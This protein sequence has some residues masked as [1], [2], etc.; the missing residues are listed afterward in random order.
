MNKRITV[1]V[2]H[3][4]DQAW[5]NVRA[6][7]EQFLLEGLIRPFVVV[8]ISSDDDLGIDPV[9]DVVELG[10]DAEVKTYTSTFFGFLASLG[11]ISEVSVVGLRCDSSGVEDNIS[12]STQLDK[13][14]QSI[15]RLLIQFAGDLRQRQVRCAIIGEGEKAPGKPFFSPLADV[16]VVAMPRDISMTRA[17][18]RPILRDN[19]ESFI[20]HAALE[21]SSIVGL[22][23]SMDSSPLDDIQAS[24]MGVPG[25]RV[26][27]VTSRVKGLLTPPLPIADLVDDSS[28]LPLPN[29]FS[30]VENLSSVVDRYADVV[31]PANMLFEPLGQ[32][33]PHVRKGWRKIAGAYVSEFWRTVI[34]IPSMIKQGFEGEI[35]A[36]GANALDRL[37]G[38]AD[39]RIRPIIPTEVTNAS[40][41]ITSEVVEEIIRDIELRE[42]RPVVGALTSEQWD[43]M[44]T[45]IL[46]IADAHPHSEAIRQS[47]MPSGI[48]VREKVRLAPKSETVGEL[49]RAIMP[50]APRI[51]EREETT[52]FESDEL[53]EP[54]AN[55]EVEGD[56]SQAHAPIAVNYVTGGEVD[57]DAL[58]DAVRRSG[59]TRPEQPEQEEQSTDADF[60]TAGVA[61]ESEN[62][63]ANLIG[64]IT[65]RFD[66]E[67]N[68]AEDSVVE[69]LATLRD[70]P[71]K[72]GSSEFGGVSRAVI[73]TVAISMGAI[74]VSLATHGV[75]RDLFSLDWTS[76]RNRDF[77]WVALSSVMTVIALAAMPSNSRR[78]WQSKTMSTVAICAGILAVE[79]VAFDAV[80]DRIIQSRWAS[81]TAVVAFI[82]LAVTSIITVLSV[83]RNFRSED[84]I[85]NRISR[86]LLAFFWLYLV[87]GASS[88]IAGPESFIINW[89]D[90]TRHKFLIAVQFVGWLCLIM[91]TLVIVTVR[92]QQRNA[93]GLYQET[94]SW[95]QDNLTHSI[96]ARRHLR[97]AYTQWLTVAAMLS[98]TIWYPLGREASDSAPF[99]G[100]LAGDESI[101]KFDLAKVELSEQGRSALLAQLKQMFVRKGWLRV[102][103]DYAING[104]QS[105]IA[106]VTQDPFGAHDP[107]SCAGVPE[108]EDLL[109]GTARGDRYLFAQQ[110]LEGKFDTRLLAQATNDNLDAVYANILGHQ[111][112]HNIVE[113]Q[114]DFATGI[115]FL[116]DIVPTEA[117]QLPPRILNALLVPSDEA[118]VLSSHRWWPETSLLG[119]PNSDNAEVH[120]AQ[121][122]SGAHLNESVVMMA[123][124]VGVSSGF[125]NSQV[126][127]VDDADS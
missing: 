106:F 115:E 17:V 16:N 15:R 58:R 63:E 123:V 75:L 70:L 2:A 52:E 11:E 72:F 57:L 43:R 36:V 101:L 4:K 8:S 45:E 39:A 42:G 121:V 83:K 61:V 5:G 21:I 50:P 99:E 48:L 56:E 107:L 120:T 85:R 108:V 127:C 59:L 13:A 71:S 27:L 32:P 109:A 81:T 69:S 22:W 112:L 105:D 102:Q 38:G 49:I 12:K 84:P 119:S 44:I 31:Y 37:L 113:A 117:A 73:A 24:P 124:L 67:F 23:L 87:L 54:G 25:Y 118:L 10:E 40:A 53:S 104:Y 6:R 96:D 46:G 18:A 91:A 66:R 79:F 111:H 51:L 76:K 125:V 80:R 92:V 122:L 34:S 82:I 89:E 74:I 77:L 35:D 41:G 64:R 28:D 94:F 98:R 14:L 7:L 90:V 65:T 19:L 3:E 103:F 93:F 88:F 110:L 30:S 100:M 126:I 116:S 47:V 29:G 9:I 86:V 60:V 68:E 1:L 114:N 62:I 55:G 33:D 97:V 95:A 78:N 20:A 26:H